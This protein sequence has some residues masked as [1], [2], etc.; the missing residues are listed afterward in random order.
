MR[1][2]PSVQVRANC[3]ESSACEAAASAAAAGLCAHVAATEP[4]PMLP[5]R[6]GASVASTCNSCRAAGSSGKS[7][8]SCGLAT[9]E[10]DHATRACCGCGICGCGICGIGRMPCCGEA[11]GSTCGT[12][13]ERRRGKPRDGP[14][15]SAEGG[16]GRTRNARSACSGNIGDACCGEPNLPSSDGI[17]ICGS[18]GDE[19]P[20]CAR[21]SGDGL[22]DAG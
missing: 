10:G 1:A 22:G 14:A 6:K 12:R 5:L 15:S 13:S 16:R 3:A 9:L 19:D 18:R 4:S 7:C 21:V 17:A 11:A 20:A 8:G 2:N